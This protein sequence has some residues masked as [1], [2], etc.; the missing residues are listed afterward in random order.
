MEAR[1]KLIGYVLQKTEDMSSDVHPGR[2][3][4]TE[5]AGA[6]IGR[7]P[8]YERGTQL[9]KS[10]WLLTT[11]ECYET[12]ELTSIKVAYWYRNS[13]SKIVFIDLTSDTARIPIIF[14][15]TDY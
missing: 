9:M 14:E 1:G 13:S 11:V 6:F 8:A 4:V 15:R 10:N 3:I 2:S 12:Y 7:L 5:V